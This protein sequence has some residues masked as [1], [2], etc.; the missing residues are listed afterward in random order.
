MSVKCLFI[1][2]PT[3]GNGQA[4]RQWPNIEAMIKE[5]FDDYEILMTQGQG[6][7]TRIASEGVTRGFDTIVSCG[8]DGTLNEVINGVVGSDVGVA[9]IPLGTG[10]DFGKTIG[11]RN[12]EGSLSALK[13][14]NKERIDIA[15]VTFSESNESRFFINILEIGFGAEV[16]K[17]VNSHS[18]HGSSSFIIGIISVLMK[19]KKFRVE[20]DSGKAKDVETIEVIVANGKYFGGGMLASPESAVNDGILDLHI[21]K[22]VS[23]ITTLFRLRNL[24]NGTY[25]EKKFSYDDR[26]ASMDFLEKGNLV[27]VDGEVVGT[28]PISIRISPKGVNFV[29][30]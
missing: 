13:K 1:V 26:V 5:R 8:G 9:L 21:L 28:T 3:A 11:I 24:M 12:V 7:A 10:S 19:L 25:I 4:G 2:N 27:E 17:Y 30:P 6:D 16:M 15:S 22:P 23:R 29:V 18:K 14:N 20:M